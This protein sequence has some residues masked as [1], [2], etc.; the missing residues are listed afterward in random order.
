MPVN[1]QAPDPRHLF[2]VP[3]AELGIAMAGV[4]KAN[5]KVTV[6]LPGGDLQIEWR[7]ADNN[8]YMTG[9]ATEVFTGEWNG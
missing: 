5:R 9:P 8:V 2:A 7:E 1:L 3:G 6:T 4:R